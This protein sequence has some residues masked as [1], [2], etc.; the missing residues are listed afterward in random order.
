MTKQIDK[1][2][3]PAREGDRRSRGEDVPNSMVVLREAFIS[4]YS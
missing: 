2:N 3:Q 1:A 4:K